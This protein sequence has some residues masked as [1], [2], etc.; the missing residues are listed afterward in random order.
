M[1]GGIREERRGEMLL[2]LRT[3]AQWNDLREV[4]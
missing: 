1:M 4:K 2:T 3:G